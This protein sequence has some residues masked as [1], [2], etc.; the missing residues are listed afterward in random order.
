MVH[1]GIAFL[2]QKIYGFGADNIGYILLFDDK[3]NSGG[4]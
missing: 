4:K 2:D 3:Q 1:S